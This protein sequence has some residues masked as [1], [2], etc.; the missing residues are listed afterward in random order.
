MKKILN[1]FFGI[2]KYFVFF[3]SLSI[4]VYI[5]LGMYQ[6]VDKDIIESSI[7][8]LSYFIL[9]FVY[10]LNI[11]LRQSIRENIFY[12]ITS[13]LVFVTT[14]VVGF[15]SILDTNMILNSIM[16]YNINFSFFSDYIPFMNILMYGLIISNIFFMFTDVKMEENVIAKKVEIEVL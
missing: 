4:T 7:I 13:C 1:T 11:I 2:F 3:L 14:L 16:G 15:R 6:R 12:N 5:V 9:F 10:I 8:F